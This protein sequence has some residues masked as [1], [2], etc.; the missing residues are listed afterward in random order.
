MFQGLEHTAISSPD[1][2]KL[3][4]W[5]VDHLGFHINFSYAGNYFVKAPNGSI[6]EIIPSEGSLPPQTMA[7]NKNPGIR[8]LA[9]AIDDFDAAHEQLKA[10]GV[11]FQSEPL[12]N[13]GN[14]LVF[15]NDGDG[16]LLHLI[17]RE[18]PLP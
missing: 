17:H 13:Q 15:F 10:K 5:Y 12:N 16:N 14:R 7:T 9:I 11:H 4:Q 3:A 1:P 18:N 8:H 6:L 2:Q